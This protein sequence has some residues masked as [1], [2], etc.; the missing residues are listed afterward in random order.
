MN[1]QKVKSVDKDL[2]RRISL[3]ATA[4]REIPGI[5]ERVLQ[6]LYEDLITIISIAVVIVCQLPGIFESASQLLDEYAA[7]DLFIKISLAATAVR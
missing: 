6:S 1:L 4:F 3:A 7:S 2:I 5:F